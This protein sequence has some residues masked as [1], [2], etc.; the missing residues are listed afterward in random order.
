L[1]QII[2]ENSLSD[3]ERLLYLNP[4]RTGLGEILIR[5]I[6]NEYH[7]VKICYLSCSAGTLSRDLE[8]LTKTNYKITR[9]T[10]YDFFPNTHHIETLVMMEGL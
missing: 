7:P 8:I 10:P 2:K 1:M 4:P 3:N 5:W 9:I 6:I